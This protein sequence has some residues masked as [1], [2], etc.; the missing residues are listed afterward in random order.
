[1]S[2]EKEIV[3]FWDH[4]F[5]AI[6]PFAIKLADIATETDALSQEVLP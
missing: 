1:M 2:T 3:V 6:E 4:A 5:E